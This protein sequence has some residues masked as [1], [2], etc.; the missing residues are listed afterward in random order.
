MQDL[1]QYR[2]NKLEDKVMSYESDIKEIKDSLKILIGRKEKEE[3]NKENF[4]RWT[5]AI[6]QLLSGGAAGALITFF[7]TK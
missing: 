2:L 4:R 7:L 5:Q 1:N 6:L 3:E